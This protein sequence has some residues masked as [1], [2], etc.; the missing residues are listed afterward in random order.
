MRKVNLINLLASIILL[1][2]CATA[3]GQQA[4]IQSLLNQVKPPLANAPQ[5]NSTASAQ[6]TNHLAGL[7]QFQKDVKANIARI[8]KK[9]TSTPDTIWVGVAPNDTLTITGNY[10][11]NGAI[12]VLLNGVLIIK[13]ATMTNLGDLIA[14]NNGKIIIDSST[15]SFPQNYF[16]QRSLTLVNKATATISNTTLSYGGFSHY[17]NVADTASITFTNVTQPDFMTSGISMHGSLTINKTNQAGEFVISDY[18]NINIKNATTV[19]LWHGFPD[20]AVINWSFGKHDTAYGY[21]FDNTKPGVKGVEYH[22]SADSCYNIMWAMMPS[23][24]SIVNIS[25]SKIRSIGLL[26]DEPKDTITVSGITD[27]ATYSTFTAPL[28][29]RTLTFSNCTVQTW[30]LYVF[31][32]NLVNLSGCI[33]GEVGAYNSSEIIGTS[34]VV[35]GSGGYHYSSDTAKIIADN[36]TATTTVRSEKTSL[37]IFAYSTVGGSGIAEAIDNSIL[38]VVQSTVPTDPQALAGSDAWFDNIN[39]TGNLF[40]DSIAPIVGSA[41]I[42]RGPTSNWM[43]FKSWQLFYQAVGATSWTPITGDSTVEVS[44]NLLSNWNT[45]GLNSGTYDLDLRLRDNYGDTVDAVKQVTLLPLILGIN[46]I[47][48]ISGINIYPNP[49]SQSVNINFNSAYPQTT[50][51]DITDITGKINL[52]HKELLTVTG[53]NILPINT[54]MLPPG[55]YLCNVS[56]NMGRTVKLIEIL[57]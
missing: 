52:I 19:L 6:N 40:A 18:A 11:N 14:I 15:I 38:I 34:Y 39:Q 20:S 37:F 7:F 28:S 54:S 4:N 32:K 55:T 21:Q 26:I 43:T 24:N 16:Y 2:K 23:H 17:L 47:N 27:N 48:N 50:T 5:I 56:N 10:T 31:N 36:A 45:H 51:I 42:H 9:P 44:N 41:W 25:N 29:D 22:I 12:V 49:A 30:S 53:E 1:I 3:F 13:N 8:S 46:E 35:D 57:K 33:L